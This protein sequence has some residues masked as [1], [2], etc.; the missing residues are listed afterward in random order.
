M[1]LLEQLY[2]LVIWPAKKEKRSTGTTTNSNA[3]TAA[4]TTTI[5]PITATAC[6]TAKGFLPVATPS[7]P[8]L[9]PVQVTV[10]IPIA[11]ATMFQQPAQDECPSL[12][13]STDSSSSTDTSSL[14]N[15]VQAEDD[16]LVQYQQ[17]FDSIA[18]L[19]G[20]LCEYLQRHEPELERFHCPQE[21]LWKRPRDVRANP[22]HL[23]MIVAELN[24]MRANKIVCPLRTRSCLAKRNDEFS[25]HQASPLRNAL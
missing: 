17:D 8:H 7:Q 10:P 13:S 4:T 3:A 16:D 22:A 20:M 1:T 15:P 24:M 14:S 11:S 9:I 12:S 23:R 18:A 6:M 19:T 5:Q 21:P 2:S 25:P